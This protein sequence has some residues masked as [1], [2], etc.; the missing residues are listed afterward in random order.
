MMIRTY[1][2]LIQIP[3]FIERYRYLRIGGKIG[4]ETFGWE[5]YFNQKFYNSDEWKAFRKD[6]IVRDL[7]CDL[8]DPEH[9]F[10]KGEKVIIHHMNPINIRDIREGSEFL[11][12]PEYVVAVRQLTHNAIHYGDESLLTEFELVERRPND[13]CPWK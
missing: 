2:E 3:T 7:G 4:E 5:R 13:T 6:I 9:P 1:T 11:M 10:A 12:N 8:A